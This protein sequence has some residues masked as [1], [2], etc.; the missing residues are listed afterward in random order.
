M[1]LNFNS[2]NITQVNWNGTLLTQVNFN[3]VKVWPAGGPTPVEPNYFYLTFTR[4]N[5]EGTPGS[6]TITNGGSG[7]FPSLL[8]SFDKSTWTAYTAD[9]P[10]TVNLNDTIYWKA[11]SAGNDG[12]NNNAL[13]ADQNLANQ[14]IL[15]GGAFDVGGDITTLLDENGGITDQFGDGSGQFAFSRIFQNQSGIEHCSNLVL[16][17]TIGHVAFHYA[18][19]NCSGLQDFPDF[20]HITK[21]GYNSF[22]SAFRG[23]SC[24]GAVD[25]SAVTEYAPLAGQ[26]YQYA[27][28]HTFRESYITSAKFSSVTTGTRVFNSTFYSCSAIANIEV[29]WTSWG[30]SLTNNWLQNAN[31]SGTFK[32]PTALGTNETISRGNSYVLSGWTV[33]NI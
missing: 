20:S 9:T 13:G 33:V 28:N 26:Q 4:E 24:A 6:V 14:F 29:G 32:C 1:A 30:S 7:Y 17:I 8:Y 18:F 15:T 5:E 27:F 31:G 25:F 10:I 21:I 2:N 16:P 19:Y 11:T 12:I 22:G 3:G 23:T